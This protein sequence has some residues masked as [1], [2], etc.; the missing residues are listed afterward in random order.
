MSRC[1]IATRSKCFKIILTSWIIV[2]SKA[3]SGVPS[4]TYFQNMLFYVAVFNSLPRCIQRS[5]SL[6]RRTLLLIKELY[7]LLYKFTSFRIF[8]A[9]KLIV[10]AKKF[11]C[12]K[13]ILTASTI[14]K[15]LSVTT[16]STFSWVIP[17]FINILIKVSDTYSAV[18]PYVNLTM[19][20]NTEKNETPL[21]NAMLQ[22]NNS[23]LTDISR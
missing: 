5:S 22:L 12:T 10:R 1:S 7:A 17:H 6:A 13:I 23:L 18:Y 8:S 21:K 20:M 4:S 3:K 19:S 14:F 15:S 2:I 16:A 9:V 11:R